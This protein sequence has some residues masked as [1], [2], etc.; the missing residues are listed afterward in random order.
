MVI[1]GYSYTEKAEAGQ[2]IIEAC[3]AK[4]TSEPTP[5]GEYRGFK[6]ELEFD[7]FERAY[8]VNSKGISHIQLLSAQMFTEI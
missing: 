7:T 2:V 3:K 6:M 8:A 1:D 4:T 5:L